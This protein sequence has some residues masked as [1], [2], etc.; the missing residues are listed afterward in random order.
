MDEV[1]AIECAGGR[2]WTK[3]TR[4]RA[5]DGVGTPAL[6]DHPPGIAP[7]HLT[8]RI[9]C[10]FIS[11]RNQKNSYIATPRPRCAESRASTPATT[12]EL[13]R[14]SAAACLFPRGLESRQSAFGCFCSLQCS[15]D[16]QTHAI[17]AGRKT[18]VISSSFEVRETRPIKP[19]CAE[20]YASDSHD[21]DRH[22][23]E[24]ADGG[25]QADSKIY[26]PVEPRARTAS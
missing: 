25:D 26:P 9:G 15:G 4:S 5:L 10:F 12:T 3:W 11:L 17:D 2:K 6:A 22:G 14:R 16:L 24:A 19:D 20:K 23:R 8:S 1:D 21:G 13:P 18:I 7:A